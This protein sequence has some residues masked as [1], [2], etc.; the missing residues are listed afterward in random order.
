MGGFAD[1]VEWF[2]V[3]VVS[4]SRL[5]RRWPWIIIAITRS[6]RLL[7]PVVQLLWVVSRCWNEPEN[8]CR[9]CFLIIC[10]AHKN[11]SA[12]EFRLVQISAR[13]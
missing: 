2:A 5:S 9:S 13:E 8:L 4:W 10:F 12:A 6:G 7:I 3:I 1:D 11:P